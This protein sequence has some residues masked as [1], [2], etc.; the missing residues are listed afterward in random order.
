MRDVMHLRTPSKSTHVFDV[1][2]QEIQQVSSM[3]ER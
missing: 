3:L 2:I 1:V